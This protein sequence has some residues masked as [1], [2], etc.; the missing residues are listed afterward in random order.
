MRLTISHKLQFIFNQILRL[1]AVSA[2][3]SLETCEIL[4]TAVPLSLSSLI[5]WPFYH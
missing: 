3:P 4:L 1:P 5:L 2:P